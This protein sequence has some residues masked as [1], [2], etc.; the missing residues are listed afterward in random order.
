MEPEI[1]ERI[2]LLPLDRAGYLQVL[3]NNLH[4]SVKSLVNPKLPHPKFDQCT[5][6]LYESI[7]A[8]V[9][10]SK[11]GGKK[12]T[13]ALRRHLANV[14]YKALRGI[15]TRLGLRLRTQ[16]RKAEWIATIAE[17]WQA[18]ATAQRW[19]AQLSPAAH[20]ALAR[21]VQA[22]QIPATLFWAEYG[23]V[24]QGTVR[25]QGTPPPW[26]APAT[27]SEELYYS[28]LLFPLAPATLKRAAVNAGRRKVLPVG[29]Q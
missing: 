19:L 17:G 20:T 29:C 24:R 26:Q 21:L 28:G 5:G 27:V 12:M 25:E 10:Q 2:A 8:S 15:A 1:W 4:I 22:D 13:A 7:R 9:C 6:Y 3:L 16:Q 14:P 18:A 11:K 23:R